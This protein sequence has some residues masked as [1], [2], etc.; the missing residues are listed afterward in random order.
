MRQ[1]VGGFGAGGGDV[2]L[3]FAGFNQ[4]GRLRPV[5][6]VQM[7]AVSVKFPEMTVAE[8]Q[9]KYLS[10]EAYYELEESSESRFDYLDGEVFENSGG[11]SRHSAIS[12]DLGAALVGRLKGKPCQPFTAD[13]RI[14]VKTST[15]RFH[16]DVSVFCGPMEYEEEEKSP[17]RHTATNPTALFEV[18]SPNNEGDTRGSKWLNAQFIESLRAFILLSQDEPIVE[19]YERQDGDEEWRYRAIRGLDSEL[20][21]ESIEVSVPLAEI[22]ERALK[23]PER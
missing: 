4:F 1:P 9:L 3:K 6:S 17:N 23:I 14:R 2:R 18:L 12:M 13:Q 7:S 16:P 10:V 19:V 11:T 5:L 15:Y 8:D 22:Y 20:V 21:I